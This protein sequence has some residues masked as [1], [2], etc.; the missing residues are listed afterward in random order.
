MPRGLWLLGALVTAGACG[1]TGP[2]SAP[3]G[4]G[5]REAAL[6][7]FRGVVRRDWGAAHAALD[8][9]SRARVSPERFAT[10]AGAYRAGLRF[11]PSGVQLSSCAEQ[12][13]RAVAHVVLTGRASAHQRFKDTVILRRGPDGWGVVLPSH[14]GRSKS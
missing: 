1:C 4:T 3:A 12:D 5:A 2:A 9:G 11:E 14:F 6:A 13:E 10:L 7:F 8:A